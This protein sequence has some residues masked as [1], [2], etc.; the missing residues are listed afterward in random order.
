ML[1]QN[2]WEPPDAC[3]RKKQFDELYGAVTELFEEAKNQRHRHKVLKSKCAERKRRAR[4]RTRSLEE[5]ISELERSLAGMI[6]PSGSVSGQT[7]NSQ[8]SQG[9]A[10]I[11]LASG[12]GL[13]SR[14]ARKKHSD[15]CKY[16][17]YSHPEGKANL[18]GTKDDDETSNKGA[19]DDEASDEGSSTDYTSDSD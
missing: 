10:T 11:D 14:K 19:S 6:D 15:Y 3:V 17:K 2:N 8:K 18:K 1:S 16:S 5:R 9:D 12:A 4:E 7:P 13:S